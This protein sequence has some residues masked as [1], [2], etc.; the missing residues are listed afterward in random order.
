MRVFE[1]ENRI[2]IEDC[3]L[4]NKE[5]VN[6]SISDHMLYNMFFT[7]DCQK[8]NEKMVQFMTDNPNLHY[9]DG[10]GMTSSC[11]IDD[12]SILRNKS[13]ITHDKTKIQ[14]CTRWDQAAPDLGRGGLVPNVESKLR[15]AEDTSFIRDCDRISEK[16][17][18]RNIPLIG[19]LAPTIQNPRHII[20]PFTRG[21][22]ITRNYIFD[23]KCAFRTGDVQPSKQI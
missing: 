4:V 8:D 1:L 21:G 17:F 16:Y 19:C 9:R 10:Y 11:F 20:M 6:K 13:H 7:N 18:D 5:L 2:G 22:D 12:D 15:S 3:S 23:E 14:L